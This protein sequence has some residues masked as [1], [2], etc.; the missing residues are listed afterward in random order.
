MSER[1]G[2]EHGVPCFVCGV[3]ED[4]EAAVSFYTELFGW[5][6]ENLMAAD[7]PGD[8]FV[9]RLRGRDVAAIVSTH[10]APAPP[11]AL[12]STLVSVD[13]VEEAASRALSAG[14]K[15]IGEPFDSPGGGRQAILADPAGAVFSAWQPTERY[16]AQL[17][18]EPSAWAM[19]A[20]N[21]NDPEGSKRFYADVLGWETRSFDMGGAEVIMWTVP[22]YVGGEPQQP[23]PRD[24][25]ATMM[26]PSDD[27]VAADPHW[28]V[29]FWVTDVDAAT[30]KVTDL[31]GQVVVPPFDIPNTGL[32]EAVVTDP[33]GATLSLTQPPQ[34]D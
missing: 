30:A 7:H 13:S 5:E 24:V 27:G 3:F 17:V 22:G 28:S 9:C 10:G 12:W 20:L 23:V 6:T 32:R 8:Y 1:N 19:S 26:P 4:P 25:V 33:Q 31:G 2:Y 34:A 15:V 11:R 29:D 18:N 16:G 14:G 21:T